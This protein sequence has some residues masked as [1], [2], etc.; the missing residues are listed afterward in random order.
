MHTA[1]YSGAKPCPERAAAAPSRWPAAAEALRW[2]FSQAMAELGDRS[3]FSAM[4]QRLQRKNSRRP[5]RWDA[6]EALFDAAHRARRIERVLEAL[7]DETHRVLGLAFGEAPAGPMAA[8]GD[9][10]SL[11]LCSPAAQA[12]HRRAHSARTL[13][14]WLAWLP[15][16]VNVDLEARNAFLSLTAEASARRDRALAAFVEMR[17]K[18]GAHV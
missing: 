9:L 7:D 16:H 4:V 11:V 12:E 3:N 13:P 15:K 6:V 14:D 5:A 1:H 2:Y 18:V 10:A 8:Y 17:R